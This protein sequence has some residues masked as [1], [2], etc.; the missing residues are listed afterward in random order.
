MYQNREVVN[1]PPLCS[2]GFYEYEIHRMERMYYL[3]RDN[4]GD[5]AAN[6]KNRRLF[7]AYTEEYDKRRGTNF[8]ETFPEF[9]AFWYWCKECNEDAA[10]TE[11]PIPH[12]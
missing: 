7:A 4:M 3:I 12:V 9:Q 2:R 5:T 8:M 10:D 11:Q 1:W 6:R